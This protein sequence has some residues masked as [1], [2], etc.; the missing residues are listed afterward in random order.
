MTMPEQKTKQLQSRIVNLAILG[1]LVTGLVVGLATAVPIYRTVRSQ[2]E[3]ATVHDLQHHALAVGQFLVRVRELARQVTSRTI[4]RDKLEQYNRGEV[5]LEELQA[6]SAPKLGDAMRQSS[7]AAGIIR[8]DPQGRDVVRVGLPIPA[9]LWP[10]PPAGDDGVM[11]RGPV[12]LGQGTYLLAGAPI[13]NRQ[14]ER[15]GTDIVAFDLAELR[16]ILASMHDTGPS[17][18][19]YFYGTAGAGVL[20]IDG[21]L[22]MADPAGATIEQ[23]L[24]RGAAGEDGFMSSAADDLVIFY[25]PVEPG[26]ALAVTLAQEALAAPAWRQLAVPAVSILVMVLLGT[27]GTIRVIR[28]LALR[29]VQQAEQLAATAEEQRALLEHARGFVYRH[30]ADGVF[31]YLSPGYEIVTG[32]AL[33]ESMINY[34]ARLTDSPLNREAIRLTEHTLRTGESNPPYLL[35][36]HHKDGR[37]IILEVNERATS[38]DGRITGVVGVARDVTERVRA[39]EALRISE[40]RLRTLIDASPDFICFKDGNGRW[41]EANGAGLA[42]LGLSKADYRGRTDEELAELTDP[43]YR[44]WLRYAAAVD[45]E[46]WNSGA[47]YRTEEI[48]V[49]P[50]GEETILDLLRV[51]LYTADRIRCRLVVLGRDITERRKAEQ[52]LARSAAEWTYAM[53]FLEDVICLLD[54]DGRVLRA[55]RAIAEV[56]GRRPDEVIGRK[57]SSLFHSTDSEDLCPICEAVQ[58]RRDAFITMEADDFSNPSGRPMEVTVKMIRDGAGS[59]IGALVG[60]HDLT[61]TRALEEELRLAASVFAGIHEGIVIADP[62]R[63]VLRV[64]RAFTELT[65]FDFEEVAGKTMQEALCA[66]A[67][68]EQYERIWK[69]V[70]ESGVWQ[71]E[72]W[73]RRKNGSMFPVWHRISALRNGRGEVLHYIS[74]FSDIT[75]KKLSEERIDHLAHYDVLTD[76]PNRLLFNDRLRHAMERAA[77]YDTKLALLYIDLDRFK[78]VNDTLGHQLGDDL[79]QVIAERLRASVRDQDTVARLGGDEF[80]VVLED[81][82]DARDAGS[83]ARKIL[84]VIGQPVNL[85]RHELFVGAS[86]GISVFPEDGKDAQTLLKNADAAMYRAKEHGRNNYQFYTPELTAAFFER[87]ELESSLRRALERDELVLYYQPQV[88]VHTGEIIGAEAL[89]RWRHPVKGLIPPDKFIALAEESGLM[90][91]LGRWVLRTACLDMRAWAAE[92]LALPRVAVNLCGQ[93]LMHGDME[94][95]VKEVLEETGLAPAALELEITETFVMSHLSSGI[96]SLRGLKALGVTLAIDDFGTGYSSLSYLKRLPLDR[97]KID[98]SFVHDIPADRDDMAIAAAIIAMAHNLNL[99]VVAEGVETQAQLDFLREHGCDEVQGFYFGRPV[100]AD[101]FRAQLAGGFRA[102]A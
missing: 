78:N 82:R 88:S 75:E 70:D 52:A 38:V 37:R 22:D 96:E 66:K 18:R 99:Q 56:T 3:T 30:D 32:Y 19:A 5:T 33:Q 6:F 86:I 1:I 60:L 40:E 93:Q 54:L 12:Q 8:L 81:L 50:D 44:D 58:G 2:V 95:V 85:R 39:E 67:D 36:M 13:F 102:W 23:A 25:A 74:L 34:T 28:P 61:R 90:V 68:D 92:G 11:L 9:G 26:W 72:A 24:R 42:L 71:G 21:L 55:N 57:L 77:R 27:L 76:L 69:A 17:A 98:R 15:V 49:A 80:A 89:L 101:E 43:A 35:E 20:T 16:Q 62:A 14:R 41:L 65:G 84:E 87:L 29:V 73:Y 51:P 47:T 7:G 83:V 97:L 91:H 64:N 79:L 46:A 10:V 31:T 48:I 94:Q 4:I 63:R 53:D 59:P 45:E 100:P